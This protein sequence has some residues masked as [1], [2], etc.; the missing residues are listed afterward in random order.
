MPDEQ[1]LYNARVQNS[2]GPTVVN[3]LFT[4]PESAMG[5]IDTILTEKYDHEL[6]EWSETDTSHPQDWD[7]ETPNTWLRER[8]SWYAQTADGLRTGCVQNVSPHESM[9][10]G[11][12]ATDNLD[13][14][15]VE[16]QVADGVIRLDTHAEQHEILTEVVEYRVGPVLDFF[17]LEDGQSVFKGLDPADIRPLADACHKLEREYAEDGFYEAAQAADEVEGMLSRFYVPG[18]MTAHE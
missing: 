11:L 13:L 16:E 3:E 1:P 4:D 5:Y 15:P 9:H 6:I 14:L 17:G 10:E 12:R 2:T 8:D 7:D 18:K